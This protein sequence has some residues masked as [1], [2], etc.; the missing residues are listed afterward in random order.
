MYTMEAEPMAG[1]L[2]MKE[3]ASAST[4]RSSYAWKGVRKQAATYRQHCDT[5]F[6]RELRLQFSYETRRVK[7]LLHS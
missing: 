3:A 6:H 5:T 2:A 4:C 7:V 1:A